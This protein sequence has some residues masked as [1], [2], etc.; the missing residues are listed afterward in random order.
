MRRSS[1]RRAE[2][3]SG[4]WRARNQGRRRAHGDDTDDRRLGEDQLEVVGRQEL[5]RLGERTDDDQREQHP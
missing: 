5:L 4:E 3:H 2:P 1:R